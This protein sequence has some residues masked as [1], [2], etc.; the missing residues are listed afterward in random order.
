MEGH[1]LSNVL[2]LEYYG[3][4]N[5][6]EG[7]GWKTM[8]CPFHEEKRPSARS[9]GKGFICNGCGVRG[10][11]ISLIKERE[12]VDYY[13]A[14]TKYEEITGDKCHALSEAAR[15]DRRRPFSDQLSESKRDYEGN[16]NIFSVGSRKRSTPRK[17]PRFSD[18]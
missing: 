5:P 17:R 14:V 6:P 10:D 12:D 11:A 18:R 7:P 9:N 13:T 16:G 8:L 1:N 2:V 4:E 3:A 15:R